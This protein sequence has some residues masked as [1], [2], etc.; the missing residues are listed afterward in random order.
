MFACV[1]IDAMSVVEGTVSFVVHST[2]RT[3][4]S[5][6]ESTAV[7]PTISREIGD[8]VGNGTSGRK[9]DMALW[10]VEEDFDRTAGRELDDAVEDLVSRLASCWDT[11]AE[12]RPDF[13]YRLQ[14][15]GSSNSSQGGFAL[16]ARSLELLGRLGSIGAEL[17]GTIY[18]TETA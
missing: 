14:F 11:L 12:L 10:I 7:R 16:S 9:M 2:V 4:A 17:W 1:T 8:P 18:L 5:F 6:T 3:A 15:H 13:E